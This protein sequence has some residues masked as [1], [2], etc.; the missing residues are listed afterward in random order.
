[1][2]DISFMQVHETFQNLTDK[3]LHERFFE[4]AVVPKESSDRPAWNI[5]EEDVQ[6]FIID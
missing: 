2:D 3:I 5:F 4:G 1:M 6:I